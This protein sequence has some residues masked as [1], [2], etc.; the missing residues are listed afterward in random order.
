M[1]GAGDERVTANG[2]L[3]PLIPYDQ[4]A[5]WQPYED[6][7]FAVFCNDFLSNCPKIGGRGVG[8]E[9]HPEVNGKHR[10]FWHL[11]SE[12][13]PEPLRT[14]DYERCARI[15][16]PRA[17]IVAAPHAE[18]RC[19]RNTRGT[20]RNLLIAVA[21]FSY[22][23]VL[24]ERKGYYFLW[25]AYFISANGQREKNRLEYEAYERSKGRVPSG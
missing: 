24:A 22:L 17:M 15:A 23:I 18:L 13:M 8:I 7:I 20:R 2:L 10:T 19:W 1:E 4:A 11:I 16:W 14:L 3:P 9:S 12:G 5:P 21:D 25:T 6:Q